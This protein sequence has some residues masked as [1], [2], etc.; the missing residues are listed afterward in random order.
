MPEK[1]WEHFHHGSDIG[2]RGVGASIEEAF[3]QVALALTAV[4]TDPLKVALLESIE[5]DCEAPDAELLLVDW[6]NSLIYEMATR[7][8]FFGRYQVDIGG[9][10]LRATAW[11]EGVDV[12]KH[13]PAVEIKGATYTCLSVRRDDAG[14]WLAQCVV[15]V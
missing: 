8:L 10:N 12:A 6:L 5:I 9:A 2:V 15:D 11:G 7:R 1:Y 3:E 14:T 13:Q 4:I